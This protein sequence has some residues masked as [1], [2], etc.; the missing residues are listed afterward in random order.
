MYIETERLILRNWL[1][2]DVDNLVEG[3][4][5]IE[6]SKWL[7]SVPF[8]YTKQDAA[9]FIEYTK[10]TKDINFAIV[11]KAENKVIGSTQLTNINNKDGIAGG[12]IWINPKYHHMGYATEAFYARNKY[13]FNVLKLRRIEN[14]YFSGNEGSHKM[15]LKMG[16]VDEGIKRKRFL[17]LAT[18]EY[19][20]ECIT[21][22]LKDEFI[23]IEKYDNV[24]VVKTNGEVTSI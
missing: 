8:P 11:L 12:G 22:L 5:N 21:G 6:V 4:N 18:H 17:C 16:Y 1:D 20:D 23:K 24:K 2:E 15:Q 14:G 10:N 3:L 13:A 9:L 7:A 19:V